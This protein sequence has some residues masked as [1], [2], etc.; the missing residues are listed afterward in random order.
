MSIRRG[1]P[2]GHWPI[3]MVAAERLDDASMGTTEFFGGAESPNPEKFPAERTDGRL[4]N[5]MTSGKAQRAGSMQ[6]MQVTAATKHCNSHRR[7]ITARSDMKSSRRIETSLIKNVY[8]SIAPRTARSP[9]LL[10]STDQLTAD[11]RRRRQGSQS[12]GYKAQQHR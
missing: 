11:Y 8:P 1:I 9:Q 10:R 3:Q 6:R 12:C 5:P 4:K 2:G 7:R